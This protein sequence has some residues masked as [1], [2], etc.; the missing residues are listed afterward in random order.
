MDS[1]TEI[2]NDARARRAQLTKSFD[3][4]RRRLSLPQLAEDALAKL[5]PE[6]VFLGR[7]QSAIKRNPLL[8]A[9]LLTGAVWLVSDA[10]QGGRSGPDHRARRATRA[11]NDTTNHKGEL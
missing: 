7:A 2:R 3:N 11:I 10:S 4:V 6:L 1:L 9:V 8:A 5:D